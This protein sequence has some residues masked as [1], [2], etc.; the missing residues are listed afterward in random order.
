MFA[1]VS[2]PQYVQYLNAKAMQR[3]IPLVGT[4]ELTPQCNMQC[5]MCYVRMTPEQMRETQRDPLTAE[6]WLGIA[7]QAKEEGMLFLLLTGGE[8][9][10][11]PQFRELY[12][13]LRNMGFLISINSNGT[14]I[15]E[16]TV[17]WLREYPPL[18]INITI[19]GASDETY[20]RLCGNPKGY[21]QVMRAIRLLRDAKIQVKLNYSITPDNACGLEEILDFSDREKLVL[22]AATYM[23]PPMRRD[24][25]SIGHNFR[26]SAPEAAKIEAR[27]RQKQLGGGDH[28]EEYCM[29]LPPLDDKAA[30]KERPAEGEPLRCGAAKNNAW[31]SWDGRMLACGMM[32]EPCV[33]MIPSLSFSKAWKEIVRKTEEIRLP[34]KCAGCAQKKQCKTC[35]AMYY[36][37]T[38][39]FDQVP[40]YRCEFTRNTIRACRELMG[41]KP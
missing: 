6:Q 10:L 29:Q 25:E 40:A 3:R 38:G 5:K 17:A 11:Y 2:S 24:K 22:Q 18:R 12:Q 14:L 16:K 27:I 21:S 37:E 41:D 32:S 23:F 1:K 26:F 39:R 15:D 31:I 7:E 4:F 33:D 9:F 19:Y 13:K 34:A 36:T 20:A 8:P 28:F 30:D 35:A